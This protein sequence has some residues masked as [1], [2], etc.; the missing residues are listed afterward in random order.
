MIFS[1]NVFTFIVNYTAADQY[2]ITT[3]ISSFC[4]VKIM[5]GL[6]RIPKLPVKVF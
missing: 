5:F 6:M 4:Q 2:I 3:T 1:K